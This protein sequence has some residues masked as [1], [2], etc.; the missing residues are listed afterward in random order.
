M[1]L[2]V[3][4]ITLFL[5]VGLVP[6]VIAVLISY[7]NS[8]KSLTDLAQNQL[9]S[10]REAKK[11]EVIGYFAEREGDITATAQNP[12]FVEAARELKKGFN[13]YATDVR[14]TEETLRRYRDAVKGYYTSDFASELKKRTTDK[15]NIDGLIP[16]DKNA[17]VAQYNYISNNNNGLGKKGNL[18]KA[19]DGS[20]YSRAHAIYHPAI[21]TFMESYGYYDVFMADPE[22]GNVFYSTAK[23][24]DFGTNLKNGPYTDSGIAEVFKEAIA[25]NAKGDFEISPFGAYIPSYTV[26]AAFTGSPVFEGDKMIAVLIFQLP[27]GTISEKMAFGK[28]WKG[29][30]L[31]DSGE[32]YL[33][34]TDKT[35][36]SESRF[37]LENKSGFLAAL[38]DS[39]ISQDVITQIDMEDTGILNLK[40]DTKSAEE[41]LNGRDGVHIIPD[42]RG[43]LVLSAYAPITIKELK[44][45]IIAEVD[46]A[47]AFASLKTLQYITIIVILVITAIVAALGFFVARSI[48]KPLNKI[49]DQLG[50]GSSQVAEASQQLSA[51]SQQLSQGSSEQASSIEETS[52]SLEEIFSMVKQNADNS[53]QANQLAISARETAEKGAKTV[54]SMIQSMVDI[55]RGSEEVSKII[56][57]INEIAFQT[58]LLALNAAVE[59]ARAGEHG[60]GF[61]VVAEEVRN[62][63]RR[64]AEAAK[65]TAGLIEQSVTKAKDGSERASEAGT[66][67]KDIVTNSKKVEDLVSEI[68]AASK[69]QS[70]GLDQVTKAI[71]QMDEVTQSISATSEES[72]SAAE[73]LSAQS[74][75]LKNMVV[76]LIEIV[77]G[78]GGSGNRGGDASSSTGFTTR[79]RKT[80]VSALHN[81]IKKGGAKEDKT[82]AAQKKG[83]GKGALETHGLE[84]T[85]AM[86]DKKIP[87]NDED[88]FKEF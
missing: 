18:M 68:S 54:E 27:I 26:A 66:V 73:E 31:G 41:A 87:M 63:A 78:S 88:E 45:G 67:L 72:A 2:N 37:F 64:S 77:G 10:L 30:G 20:Y 13:Q 42:Y 48:A 22:T 16:A 4:L 47:E 40:I 7:F 34:G 44:W 28:N 38:K 59:A 17:V 19:E 84:K 50:E 74:D 15:I 55:N 71:S 24:I 86:M 1:S 8:S 75:G 43:A 33:V 52:A 83:N 76:T 56:K 6:M 65:E 60:K 23:E 70:D 46:E 35:L 81:V 21:R 58:N 14:A 80:A 36:R 79:A 12:T 82:V 32:V 57:V 5:L 49:I 25:A 9:I 61:A 3:K 85:K 11:S 69:E 62:L 51:S 53:N 29:V 39:N